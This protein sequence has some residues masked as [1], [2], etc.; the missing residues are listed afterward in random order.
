M[1]WAK[2]GDGRTV[3]VDDDELRALM[4]Q[5]GAEETDAPPVAALR[6][7]N[8]PAPSALDVTQPNYAAAQGQGFGPESWATIRDALTMPFRAVAG[9]GGALGTIAG[10]GSLS[11][12]G[13]SFREDM[14]HPSQSVA[15]MDQAG[16]VPA[17]L[18]YLA[19][20]SMYAGMAE[21]PATL[22]GLAVGGLPING[23]GQGLALGGISYAERQAN[24]LANGQPVEALPS[25][26]DLLPV[27]LGAGG[28]A[29]TALPGIGGRLQ[30]GAKALIRAQIKTS[31]KKGGIVG[32]GLQQ[33][34]DAGY[35]PIIAGRGTISVPQMEKNFDKVFIPTQQEFAPTLR[36]MDDAGVRVSTGQAVDAAQGHL[37]N[38]IAGG[39]VIPAESQG[40]NALDWFRQ[41]V[42]QPDNAQDVSKVLSGYNEP[43]P[44][45]PTIANTVD[46]TI[47]PGYTAPGPMVG[48]P[49]PAP[50]PSAPTGEWVIV[51]GQ[52]RWIEGTP[53]PASTQ[54]GGS[55]RQMPGQTV[56]GQELQTQTGFRQLPGEYIAPKT[57]TTAGGYRELIPGVQPTPQDVLIGPATAHFRKSGILK[58]AFKN[59]ETA[60]ANGE[61]AMGGGMNLRQQLIKGGVNPTPDAIAAGQQYENLM[62][63]AA[64]LYAME[65]AMRQ[66]GQRANR[67]PLSLYS[68]LKAPVQMMQELPASARWMYDAGGISR[69]LG[70]KTQGAAPYL[71]GSPFGGFLLNAGQNQ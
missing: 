39:G 35:L 20:P 37:A 41:R 6:V 63:R 53:A 48:T 22:P 16:Q 56:P 26:R 31:A 38:Y 61:V 50:A 11:D 30:E 43:A 45:G 24:A 15:T 57:V 25:I 51:G 40:R 49:A 64:P 8:T 7:A 33:G 21:S 12:A 69:S 5:G 68:A 66:A 19:S 17:A 71:Q 44:R 58:E 10:G 42:A 18:R 13:V 60:T 3:Q 54:A 36:A 9:A 1:A 55:F 52:K 28:D 27:A 47:T 34:L 2:L 62:Q 4:V 29:V 59:P 32:Q 67:Y 14:A 23:I 46:Q 70:A 65:A